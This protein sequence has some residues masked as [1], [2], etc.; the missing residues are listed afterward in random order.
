MLACC[1]SHSRHNTHGIPAEERP[2]YGGGVV[3]LDIP[4]QG[5]IGE[6]AVALSGGGSIPSPTIEAAGQIEE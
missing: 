1:N 4:G 5:G 3:Y 2:L 6:V